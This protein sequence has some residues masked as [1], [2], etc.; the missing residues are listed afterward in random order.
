[1]HLAR[2]TQI[3]TYAAAGRCC[4]LLLYSVFV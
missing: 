2:D 3:L 1:V 4:Y